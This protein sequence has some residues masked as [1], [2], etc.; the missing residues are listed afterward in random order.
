MML[1]QGEVVKGHISSKMYSYY[2]IYINK[3]P[4]VQYVPLL[5]HTYSLA[6]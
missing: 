3:Y 4:L 2:A 1:P 5:S 6:L